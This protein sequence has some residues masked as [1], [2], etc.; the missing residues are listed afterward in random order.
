MKK[1]LI[2]QFILSIIFLSCGDKLDLTEFS[3]GKKIEN[4]SD[5][6]YIQL[7]PVW[8]GFNNPTDILIGKE[9]FIYVADTDNDRV[10]MLNTA[11]L[12]LGTVKIKRPV[13]LAQDYRLNLLVCAEFDT[14]I[15]GESKVFGALYK[16]DMFAS[17]N[18][19]GSAPLK[20]LLPSTS[21]HF[22]KNLRRYTGVTVFFDNSY[23]VTR[24]GPDNTS[25]ID[26]DNAI[27]E[28][29]QWKNGDGTYR[30]SL[31]GRLPNFEANG[32]GLLSINQLSSVTSFN[33]KNKEIV[34]A[35]IGNTS[36]KV[37]WLR[38]IITTD[39]AG[40]VSKFD[41]GVEPV[42]FLRPNKFD[43]PADVTVD[44]SNNIFIVDSKKDSLFKFNQFGTE[45][46]SFGGPT[47]FKNPK[48]VAFHD[49]TL[50]ICDSGNNRILRFILSTDTN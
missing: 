25:P 16:I 28:F 9:P 42:D 11:G 3:T 24:V 17:G 40:Y 39:Y 34:T 20:R 10:V 32:S 21:S 6:S 43:T 47:V 22:Q 30:D 2:L 26:P 27:L 5:T 12:I 36:F 18:Q 4:P 37:Q 14:T 19:L 8:E 44:N 1:I 7:K 29:T 33:R 45:Q 13:A 35:Q 23:L 49:R 50:Y 38:F 31:M 48:G 46:H 15:G 41:P